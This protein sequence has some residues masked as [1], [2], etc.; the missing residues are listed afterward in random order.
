[1]SYYYVTLPYKR[2]CVCLR[3]KPRTESNRKFGLHFLFSTY[4]RANIAF[5]KIWTGQD[6]L[7]VINRFANFTSRDQ[8]SNGYSVDSNK[9]TVLLKVLFQ[10]KCLV[11]IKC[12]IYWKTSRPINCH[13]LYS[14]EQDKRRVIIMF[15][16]I[17]NYCFQF[18]K[19][20]LLKIQ[21]V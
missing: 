16:M 11:S 7:F 12:T 17:S 8:W 4:K 9:C 15:K 19:K 20:S 2:L 18:F 13:C 10:K 1:M 21:Y 14:S 5:V 6:P 3:L